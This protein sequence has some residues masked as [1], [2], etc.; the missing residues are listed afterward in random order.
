MIDEMV[1]S[2]SGTSWKEEEKRSGIDWTRAAYK[3]DGLKVVQCIV[4]RISFQCRFVEIPLVLQVLR[5][6]FYSVRELKH[7]CQREV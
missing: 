5:Q 4:Y 7:I 2:A 6:V 3:K 1:R